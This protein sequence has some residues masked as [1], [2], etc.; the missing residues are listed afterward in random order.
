MA[1]VYAYSYSY[2]SVLCI[3]YIY[4]CICS[5]CFVIYIYLFII[6]MYL[7]IIIIVIIIIII[8]DIWLCVEMYRISQIFMEHKSYT[9]SRHSCAGSL[10]RAVLHATKSF[11]GS[12]NLPVWGSPWVTPW[13]SMEAQHSVGTP[14]S[15][16]LGP[17]GQRRQKTEDQTNGKHQAQSSTSGTHTWARSMPPPKDL[18]PMG[19]IKKGNK[20]STAITTP[21]DKLMVK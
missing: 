13:R 15:Q 16:Q 14:A 2:T 8:Y 10:W 11:L 7:F 1:F 17:R 21:K 20:K 5:Y 9:S 4:V 3:L 18:V 19:S 12:P 6:Y